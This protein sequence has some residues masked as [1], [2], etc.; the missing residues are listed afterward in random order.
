MKTTLIRESFPPFQWPGAL[1]E[2]MERSDGNYR[3]IS[4]RQ[5]LQQLIDN[6]A[7]SEARGDQTPDADKYSH[8]KNCQCSDRICKTRKKYLKNTLQP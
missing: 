2:R 8:G 4:S 1:R 5:L 6:P 3:R 7:H